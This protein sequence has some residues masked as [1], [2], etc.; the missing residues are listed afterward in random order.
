MSLCF[1]LLH[2]WYWARG[3]LC[4]MSPPPRSSATVYDMDYSTDPGEFHMFL[5]PM[6][7]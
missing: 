2:F 6:I 4:S 7:L 3:R 1:F 5:L